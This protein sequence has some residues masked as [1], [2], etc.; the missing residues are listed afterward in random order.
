MKSARFE[1]LV[2]EAGRPRTYLALIEPEKDPTLQAALKAGRVLTVYQS[3]V[4]A[5]A[6]HGAVGFE[7]G[8]SRQFFIFPRN[9]DDFQARRI[10]GIKYDLLGEDA[11]R[12]RRIARKGTSRGGPRSPAKPLH[13][14]VTPAGR[15]AKR[16]VDLA[17]ELRA[18]LKSLREGK[19]AQAVARLREAL[20]GEAG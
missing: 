11:P 18:A 14:P 13:P 4:G 3:A 7:P 1:K 20:E 10:V 16:E 17:A 8:P 5:K 6:D 19:R 12:R 9:L 2:E 15:E